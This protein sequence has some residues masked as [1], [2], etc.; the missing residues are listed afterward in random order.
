MP[1]WSIDIPGGSQPNDR[2]VIS[3]L[4]RDGAGGPGFAGPG[5]RRAA[6]DHRHE[7]GRHRG[8]GQQRA[9]GHDRPAPAQPDL[10]LA[11]GEVEVYLGGG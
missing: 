4:N 5:R 11:A 1:P 10:A 9:A 6:R 7:E 3:G 2:F 8:R